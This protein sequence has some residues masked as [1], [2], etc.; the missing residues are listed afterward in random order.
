LPKLPAVWAKKSIK[1]LKTFGFKVYRQAGGHIHHGSEARN[2]VATAPN[3]P[4]LQRAPL[5]IG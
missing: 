3:H 2:P 4:E 5:V 1:A